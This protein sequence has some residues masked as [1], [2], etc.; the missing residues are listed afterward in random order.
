MKTTGIGARGK[1]YPVPSKTGTKISNIIRTGIMLKKDKDNNQAEI[2]ENKKLLI[3]HAENLAGLCG[4]KSVRFKCSFGLADIKFSD[5]IKFLKKDI[6]K[7]KNILGPL[8]EQ[9][10]SKEITYAVNVADIPE[11]KKI[12]GKNYER[13]VSEQENF[14]HK[15]KIRDM[16]ADGDNPTG[17]KLRK[18]IYIEQSKPSV[19]FTGVE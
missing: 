2:E 1:E 14:K 16:L 13:L 12:L 18:F 9:M 4:Q 17:K 5:S 8:F 19:A 15:P 10:F 11:I 3:P 6:T 7:I